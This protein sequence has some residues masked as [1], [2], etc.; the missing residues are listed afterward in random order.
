MDDAMSIT[1]QNVSHATKNSG[2]GRVQL[3]GFIVLLGL[4]LGVFFILPDNVETVEVAPIASTEQLSEQE[5]IA[6]QA[7][8]DSPWSDAQLA[9][10]RREAQETLSKVIVLQEKLED[11]KVKQWAKDQFEQAMQTTASGDELY[12]KREFDQAQARYKEGLK[13]FTELNS[14]TDS[15]FDA[16]MKQGY[17]AI[18]NAQPRRA[19]KAFELASAIKP[20]NLD[21]LE[22]L[23]RA[24]V[25]NQVIDL[26]AKGKHQLKTGKLQDAKQTLEQALSL[27]GKSTPAKEQLAKTQTAIVDA[28]FADAMSQGYAAINSKDYKA[29][30]TAFNKAQTI[31]P[32]AADTKTALEQAQN[33]QLQSKVAQHLNAADKSEASEQWQAANDSFNQVLALD[34]SVI[35]AKVGAIRTK[36]RMELDNKLQAAIDKSE[37]LT[38]GAVHRQTRTL[39]ADAR[40]VKN[41]GPRLSQQISS[42]TELLEKLNQ[43]VDVQI[44]SNNQ[45]LV[46]LYRVGSLGSFTDKR[47]SLK[48]GKYTLVGTRQGYRDVREE[49][50]IVPGKSVPTV[51]VQCE[52]KING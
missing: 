6:Q 43:P 17:E 31:K 21:A 38:D 29:A 22:G 23:E 51:V 50:T 11:K 36:A 40:R 39:V 35:K 19:I 2:F 52:E 49:F 33:K 27:D 48:P 25:Q 26:I 30:I 41:P 5:Q 18:K 42:L 45:T 8:P 10:Q 28:N 3:L 32:N 20:A 44:K 12:R 15:V 9:K 47:M 46:T 4:L 16:Q 24:K 1:V 34:S 37:R 13:L 7:P 14:Q